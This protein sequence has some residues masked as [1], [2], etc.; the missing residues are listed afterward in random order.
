M[1][2]A[3]KVGT[4]GLIQSLQGMPGD[5]WYQGEHGTLRMV[6]RRTVGLT[7]ALYSYVISVLATTTAD[8]PR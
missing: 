5:K 1:Q 8:K 4:S 7:T 3:A 2:T 6:S